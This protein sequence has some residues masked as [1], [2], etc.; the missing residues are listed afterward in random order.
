MGPCDG[1]NIV[2]L[3][4]DS[5]DEM[6]FAPSQAQ[7][8]KPAAKKTPVPL[9]ANIGR[10]SST[11]SPAP[12]FK[13]TTATPPTTFTQKNTHFVEHTTSPQK[14]TT[15]TLPPKGSPFL[16]RTPVPLPSNVR[17]KTST[18]GHA[19][20]TLPINTPTNP[21]RSPSG[22]TQPTSSNMPSITTS[23]AGTGHDAAPKRYLPVSLGA[24]KNTKLF[25]TVEQAAKRRK[26]S[27]PVV[28]TNTGLSS[29]AKTPATGKTAHE[30]PTDIGAGP[31]RTSRKMQVEEGRDTD[32]SACAKSTSTY[33]PLSVH[34]M[35]AAL[36]T[37]GTAIPMMNNMVEDKTRPPKKEQVPEAYILNGL[38]RPY[39][40]APGPT[41]RFS[42][43]ADSSSETADNIRE[44][45]LHSQTKSV[46]AQKAEVTIQTAVTS[47]SVRPVEK[48]S[49]PLMQD[50][51]TDSVMSDISNPIPVPAHVAT[52]PLPV[53]NLRGPTQIVE[54]S[55]P[56]SQEEDHLLIF[57][58]EVAQF[59]WNEITQQFNTIYPDRK[60]SALQTCYSSRLNR[61]DRSKDPAV[62]NLPPRFS[63]MAAEF[64]DKDVVVS[65]ETSERAQRNERNQPSNH[66][67]TRPPFARMTTEY[68]SGTESAPRRER[69]RRAP[70]VNYTWPRQRGTGPRDEVDAA[71]GDEPMASDFS[72]RSETPPEELD[73]PPDKAIAVDN[74]PIDMEFDAN[75]AAVALA[76]RK[77]HR[78]ASDEPLPY[79]T[80]K[81][82][83]TMQ[84]TPNEYGWDQLSSREWQGL[85]VHVDFSPAEIDVVNRVIAKVTSLTDRSSRHNTRRRHLRTVLK[86]ITE[87]KLLR[88]TSEVR[89]YLSSRDSTSIA[90]FLQDAKAGKISDTPQIQRLAAA[91]TDKDMS[92]IQKLS[93]SSIIRQRELGL[94]SRRGWKSASK[95][96]TYQTK[97]KFMDTLGC[98]HTWTG[99]SGDI[100]TVA[101]SPGGQSFV[102]GAVAVTD[103]DSM[104]YNRRNNLLYGDVSSGVIHEL[105][106]H[107]IERPK[108]ETGAN[109]THAMFVSQDPKLYTTVSSVRFSRS[110]KLMY[111]A[112][113][114]N[115]VCVWRT[116]T[117]SSQ[118]SFASAW[119]HKAEVDMMAVNPQYD[120]M[121]ATAAKRSSENT[122]K[123]ISAN[124]DNPSEFTKHNYYSA[125]AASRS[126]LKILPTALQFEPRYGRLLLAGFGANVR[127]DHNLDTTGDICLWDVETQVPMAVHGSSKNI[128]DITFNPNHR[129]MPLFAYGCVATGGNINK[130]T[131]S[132][133]RLYE[134]ASPNKYT[135]PLEM[136]CKALDMNDVVW[137]PYDEH[138]IAAGCT[139]GRSYVWD[140]RM[141]NDPLL[142][143]LHGQSLMPL[144]DDVHHERTDTGVRFLS[145]GENA[146]RLYSGSSDGVVKV[147][148]VTR[149]SKDTFIRDLITTDSGIMAGS[150]SPDMSRLIIG[151]VN[152]SINIL[153][154]G[155][156]DCS[157]KDADT[158][159][160]VPYA[161]DDDDEDPIISTESGIADANHLLQTR[162]LQL[163]PMGSLPIRQVL[164]GPNYA[165]PFDHSVDA[166]FLRQQALNFQLN[167]S[168]PSPQCTIPSCKHSMSKLT[169]EEIGDSGRSADR[170]PDELRRQ[171]KA[172][173]SH[174]IV[175]GKSKCT[176]CGRSAR[177]SSSDPDTPILCERCSFACFRCGAV[178]PVAPVTTTLICDS[179]A[180]VWEIGALGFECVQQPDYVGEPLDVPRLEGFGK[181]GCLRGKEDGQATF[182]DEVNALTDYYYSLAIDRPESPP[183]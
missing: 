126:D 182:G 13:K 22:T 23:S 27:A 3:T 19:P 101:W 144:Q 45:A 68:S 100:H 115:S 123:L 149:S 98:S 103:P 93:T 21:K 17:F 58:K 116:D 99:A 147:W 139:D 94:Q 145:W 179:C 47:R 176:H 26:L 150:F 111:S 110:G 38:L 137:C 69:A 178:N 119:K 84:D 160:Y 114:D 33:K 63:E 9:P 92:S 161:N 65:F 170:I 112:G 148:D 82:R 181:E 102:A 164:Q 133:V 34:Q 183:L 7:N 70:P 73:Q 40:T 166:P 104:Q 54:R 31:N 37:N 138:L 11:I 8:P 55:K 156:N 157:S 107:N 129:H 77:G 108:T 120:G 158:L 173:D 151:E 177:L 132:L 172:L 169:S 127:Q 4:L 16:K 162:Q 95:P 5:D 81:Q 61:R 2:D 96:L 118:P 49:M 134:G 56:F 43:V 146:T 48:K 64:A 113:Y 163:A 124:E 97:N 117:D 67:T 14:N 53:P 167:L 83:L 57:L 122:I 78:S 12:A 106:E 30:Q 1:S 75:D 29:A 35:N 152:G 140:M 76:A 41:L 105:G 71:D 59:K 171:W 155:R 143:L 109:S 128:F 42:R 136:E 88:I 52:P 46:P 32:P 121:L 80:S 10:Q 141:P 20:Q 72:M 25:N 90:A 154:V 85:I 142:V 6:G 135:C 165:G 44:L 15:T 50:E 180:G 91:K 86:S 130:G 62:L 89:R 125:K 28:G 153:E 51:D 168:K 79:L 24:H 60:Y 18:Q 159:R 175:P 66:P 131:R 36:K 39:A 174:L 87:P 74:A